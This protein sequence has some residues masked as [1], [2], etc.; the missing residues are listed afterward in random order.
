[1]ENVGGTTTSNIFHFTCITAFL[2]SGCPSYSLN[3]AHLTYLFFFCVIL[4]CSDFTCACHI[5]WPST[6][7]FWTLPV[8]KNIGQFSGQVDTIFLVVMV[9]EAPSV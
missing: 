5:N 7:I 4:H 9:K 3:M 6:C 2:N 1:M 8:I